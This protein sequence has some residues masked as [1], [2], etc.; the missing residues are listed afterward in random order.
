MTQT[1]NQRLIAIA[2]VVII[3]LLGINGYL[4]YNKINQDKLIKQQNSELID[5]ENLQTQLEKEYYQALSDLEEMKGSNENLNALIESQKEELK[6]QKDRISVLLRSQKDLDQARSEIRRLREMTNQY[7]AEI[8]SLKEENTALSQT[9]LEL[10]QTTQSLSEEIA[11]ERAEKEELITARAQLVSEKAD[12]EKEKA[13]LSRK[14]NIASVVK[15]QNI[16][17]N[18]YKV[19]NSGK[20]S[21]KNR[22]KSIDGLKICFQAMANDIIDAGKESFFVRLVNPLGETLA[23]EDLGS[24]VL[25]TASNEPVRYTQQHDMDYSNM[26]SNAC[27]NWQPGTAFDAGEYQVEIY[28]KGYLAGTS[29]FALK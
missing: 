27:V 6:N 11:T 17:V 16:E 10:Q 14:V 3:A 29:A 20:E 8:E 7:I 15:V 9:N 24:G 2:T 12:I 1:S 19:R 28:N 22:A 21:E 23:I 26:Q 18:G 25:N 13:A 4:F 5:A